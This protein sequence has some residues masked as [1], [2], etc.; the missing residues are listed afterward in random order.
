MGSKDSADYFYNGSSVVQSSGGNLIFVVGN[1]RLGAFGWLAGW[2]METDGLP[3]AGLHDQRAVFEWVQTYIDL[4]GGNPDE[5]TAWGLSAGGGSIFHHLV[6]K[7]GTHNPLFK[8]AILQSPAFATRWD[9]GGSLENTFNRF[10]AFA[11]CAD[12]G[13]SCLRAASSDV[14]DRANRLLQLGAPRGAFAV[15][16]SADGQYIRQLAALEYA[17][18]KYDISLNVYLSII[19]C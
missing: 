3:N 1:Y 12:E 10:A 5:V 9:R 4:L 8:R 13:L 14:L 17:S 7:G 6:A 19:L 18:G 11:N 2:T 16:P 15:G